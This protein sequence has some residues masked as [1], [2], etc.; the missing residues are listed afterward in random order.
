[1]RNPQLAFAAA[2]VGLV[3]TALPLGA[4]AALP[5]WLALRPGTLARVDAAP[6]LDADEPEA[7]LTES[8]ASLARDFG[9]D[10]SRPSD[11]AYAPIGTLV[12]VVGFASANVARVRIVGARGDAFAPIDRLAPQI[13][14]GTRLRAAGGFGGAADFFPS[15]AAGAIPREIATG[16][17][18]VA[19][20]TGVAN[21]DAN[22]GDFVRTRVR[23]D[24][25][26][27]RG[28]SGWIVVKYVGVPSRERSSGNALVE[29][30]CD[31]RL[32]IFER[33]ATRVE[34]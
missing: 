4:R 32:A 30:A 24:A 14:P 28:S 27:L 18:L 26:P 23:I 13:P 12:R 1:M 33:V 9:S 25:G 22:A 11:V 21:F 15:L 7:A 16:T 6:W 31:C 8:A 3:A 17:S 10:A 29:R 20:G 5:P 2:C 34:K 19:L